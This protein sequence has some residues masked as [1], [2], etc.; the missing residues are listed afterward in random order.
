MM[1]QLDL[2]R[3]AVVLLVC[4]LP[5]CGKSTLVNAILR[6]DGTSKTSSEMTMAV[7]HIEYDEIYHEIRNAIEKVDSDIKTETDTPRQHLEFDDNKDTMESAEG[8]IAWQ[9][10]RVVA[11]QRVKQWL[12]LSHRY[13]STPT[14]RVLLLDDNFFLKSMRKQV[15]RM[16]CNFKQE[17]R[18][19]E[20]MNLYFGIIHLHASLSVCL[21]RNAQR[22]VPVAVET[23]ERMLERFEVPTLQN[24]WEAAI[25]SLEMTTMDSLPDHVRQVQ[26]FL[27]T[28]FQNNAALVVSRDEE[29]ANLPDPYTLRQEADLFWRRCVGW[30]AQ[31]ART[32]V[33]QANRVRKYCLQQ[34]L[35]SEDSSARQWLSLF[36]QGICNETSKWLTPEEHQQ[37]EHDLLRT[38]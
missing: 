31:K 38:E 18:S 15:Y 9:K 16:C 5:G 3:N 4:G 36:V 2:I 24:P 8:R 37:M 33:Q 1:S 27:E 26:Y 30:V 11:L 34:R 23:I 10:S 20:V 28:I 25:L 6:A 14:T 12:S 35:S 29:D 17:H 13:D 32:K 21:Q 22:P 19:S 7:D